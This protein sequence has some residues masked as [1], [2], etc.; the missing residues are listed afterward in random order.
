MLLPPSAADAIK[1][2]VSVPT[3]TGK[4]WHI[5]SVRRK[6]HFVV[7]CRDGPYEFG[8]RDKLINSLNS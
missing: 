8:D 3:Q 6:G 5:C 1:I 2:V 7:K 4:H